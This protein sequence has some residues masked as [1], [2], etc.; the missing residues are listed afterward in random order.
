MNYKKVLRKYYLPYL[1]KDKYATVCT[2]KKRE[3][4]KKTDYVI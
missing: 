4:Q 3:K 1:V 2:G